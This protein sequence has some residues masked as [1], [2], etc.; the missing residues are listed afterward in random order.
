MTVLIRQ[1][2][3]RV[4]TTDGVYGADVA[5]GPGLNVLRAN[6]SAGKSTLTSSLVYALGLEG[7]LGPQHAVPL[8]HAMTQ[9]LQGEDGGSY[10]VLSSY[11]MVELARDDGEALTIRRSVVDEVADRHL[12]RTW[13][14]P[15]L[16][17]GVTAEATDYYVRQPGAAQEERGFHRFLANWFGWVL[18]EVPR[19]DGSFAP[20]YPEA[21]APLFIVEQK[22]GWSGL[23][24]QTPTYL[25]LR[26]VKERAREFVLGLDALAT[27]ARLQAAET[28]LSEL[29]STWKTQL[30]NVEGFLSASGFAST[31]LPATPTFEWPPTPEPSLLALGDDTWRPIDAERTELAAMSQRAEQDVRG[32]RR[33]DAVEQRELQR[34]E[35]LLA[36]LTAK[37]AQARND[38]ALEQ[39]SLDVAVATEG[40]LLVDRRRHN[41][42]IRLRRL[43]SDVTDAPHADECPV[44][45]QALGELLLNITDDVALSVEETIEYVDAQIEMTRAVKSTSA[46][47]IADLNATLTALAQRASEVRSRIRATR[48]DLVAP[49]EQPSVEAVQQMLDLRRRV[50]TLEKVEREWFGALEKLRELVTEHVDL[51]SELR[52]LREGELSAADRAKLLRLEE[53]LQQQLREYGFDS[54][55]VSDIYIDRDNYVPTHDGYD[56]TFESSASDVIRTIWAFLLALL[57]V[58][59]E[60]GNHPG[61]LLFDEPRQQMTAQM[62]FQELL[63]RAGALRSGQV[64]FAT[65]ESPEQLA[66]MLS[67]VPVRLSEFSGKVL[68]RVDADGW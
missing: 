33:A 35:A 58:G 31:G 54:F 24:S 62:S 17:A 11:V 19:Y 37:A 63:N 65:S 27:R 30:A 1:V 57:E 56:L 38:L 61:F 36:E 45:H 3:L 4:V 32:G 53:A 7:I 12:V 23:Q 68:T 29:R 40:R 2:R 9:S 10:P 55:D 48:E 8:P 59:L 64:I 60:G 5:L 26:Q 22:R 52:G 49:G 25:Q 39:Q 47:S 16:T 44:C 21:I 14:A 41:D 18:P 43:G 15:V 20:L 46:R 50:E 28:R 13:Q 67:G 34:A 6:N 66:S 42:L 51:Q